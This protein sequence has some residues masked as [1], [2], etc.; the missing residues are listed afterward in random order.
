MSAAPISTLTD[1]VDQVW[2]WSLAVVVGSALL[3]LASFR[4][5]A[6]RAQV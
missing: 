2:A 3:V 5:A 6:K 1:H 4:L